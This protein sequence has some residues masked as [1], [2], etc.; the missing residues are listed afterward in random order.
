MG[1]EVSGWDVH[2][3]LLAVSLSQ[4]FFC[5]AGGQPL[6]CLFA[7]STAGPASTRKN[8]FVP[9][10]GRIRS[11]LCR[12][13][14]KMPNVW[15]ERDWYSPPPRVGNGH[16]R[17]NADS[18]SAASRRAARAIA[19]SDKK[20]QQYVATPTTGPGGIKHRPSFARIVERPCHM[21]A[22]S[23]IA[24]KLVDHIE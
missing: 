7:G 5:G 17:T 15:G 14:A 10:H 19:R 20:M 21:R 11:G 13:A 22:H 16:F 1:Q 12:A 18:D 6:I 4:E 8:E 23:P 24:A 3:A 9:P 2:G